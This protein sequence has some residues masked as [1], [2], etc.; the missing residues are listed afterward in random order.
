MVV[1]LGHTISFF[2]RKGKSARIR[3]DTLYQNIE[4]YFGT[5]DLANKC[6]HKNKLTVEVHL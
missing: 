1:C 4:M 3:A 5:I 2:R 6:I